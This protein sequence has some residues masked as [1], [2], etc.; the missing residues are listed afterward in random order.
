MIAS[1]ATVELRLA[2]GRLRKDVERRDGAADA[3]V[4]E[5]GGARAPRGRAG[6]GRR[7]SAASRI[8]SRT[9]GVGE[10]AQ[11]RPLGHDH[12]RVGAAHRLEHRRR[13][14]RRR[15]SSCARVGDRIPAAHLGALGEQPDA[16]TS[17]GASRMSSVSGLNASPSSATFLPRSEPR[18]FCELPDHAPLLELVDLDHR[19]EQLEVVAGVR[20]ELLERERVLREAG[21]A[22]ADARR[23]GSA[24]RAGGRGRC[25]RRP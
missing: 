14:A 18:C 13:R 5:A 15:G 7:R 2:L 8:A 20:R 12:G 3:L 23:A 1:I 22:V 24:G 6:C 4:D 17:D 25:P 19:G 16:S 21:A 10:V 11:L 9:S